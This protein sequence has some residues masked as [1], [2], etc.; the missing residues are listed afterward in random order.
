MPD[1]K[2][3]EPEPCQSSKGASVPVSGTRIT[4]FAERAREPESLQP[5][6]RKLPPRPGP[7]PESKEVDPRRIR[8]R[9]DQ[10]EEES[11]G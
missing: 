10:G 3:P 1:K 5:G 8:N 9:P 11:S 4:N 7:V 2:D 6:P